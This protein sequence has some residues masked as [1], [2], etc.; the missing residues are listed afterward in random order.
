MPLHLPIPDRDKINL[1]LP[2]FTLD[3][4]QIALKPPAARPREMEGLACLE[5]QYFDM[6]AVELCVTPEVAREIAQGVSVNSLGQTAYHR[7]RKTEL[8]KARP[9]STTLDLT[10]EESNQ[11]WTDVGA[12]LWPG[13]PC[14]ALTAQQQGDVGQLFFH[15]VCNSGA[16]NAAFVTMDGNFLRRAPD[17]RSRYGIEVTDPNA[18][19]E[20]SRRRYSLVTP[21]AAELDSLWRRQDELLRKLR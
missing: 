14:A 16:A 9:A 15:L 13:V 12:H 20:E 19:W 21:T 11:L 1:A 3:V 4:N 8:F 6:H 18:A 2:L 7:I 5:Y 10:D 17:L